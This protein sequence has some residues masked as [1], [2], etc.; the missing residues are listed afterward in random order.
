M[1]RYRGFLCVLTSILVPAMANL[2]QEKEPLRTVVSQNLRKTKEDDIE[3]RIVGGSTTAQGRYPYMVSLWSAY[4]HECGGILVAP[5]VILTAAHCIINGW[6]DPTKEIKMAHVGRWNKYDF[7]EPST[8]KSSV[9]KYSP[10]S[11]YSPMTDQ[12]DVALLK[13]E[14]PATSSPLA[15]INALSSAYSNGN[16]FTAIGWGD[17]GGGNFPNELQ[18]VNVQYMTNEAC[19]AFNDPQGVVTYQDFIYPDMMCAYS[20]GKDACFGDSGGPLLIKGNSANTD[21]IVGITSWGI[22]CARLPGVYARLDNAEIH[23]WIIENI[24]TLSESPP[25]KYNCPETTLGSTPTSGS[26]RDDSPAT[27]PPTPRPTPSPTLPPTPKPTRVYTINWSL[28]PAFGS[29]GTTAT[30]SRG[31]DQ[32]EKEDTHQDEREGMVWEE[33]ST[34]VVTSFGT[35]TCLSWAVAVLSILIAVV[36][37]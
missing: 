21:L 32:T 28:P 14:T 30:E 27:S 34:L 1:T 15:T 6:N 12:Y 16:T 8:Y 26:L 10:H 25:S 29:P 19:K 5:D 18:E 11:L 9:T 36:A 20:L 37:R 23:N 31:I 7:S 3:A 17:M 22:D 2:Q 35:Q 33:D 24:C 4:R 13:I